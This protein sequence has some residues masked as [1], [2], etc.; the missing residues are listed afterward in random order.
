MSIQRIVSIIKNNLLVVVF[1]TAIILVIGATTVVLAGPTTLGDTFSDTLKIDSSDTVQIDT[2]TGEVTLAQCYQAT[3]SG[4][5]YTAST[6]VRDVSQTGD[7]TATVQ[8]DIY[9]DDNNCLFWTHNASPPDLTVCV[10]DNSSVYQ[11]LLW[12]K[13]DDSSGLKWADASHDDVAI[14]GYQ[15]AGSH[16]AGL[17]VG[18]NNQAPGGDNWLDRYYNSPSSPDDVFPAMDTCKD[19]GPRWRLPTILE[20]DGIRDMTVSSSPYTRLPD[21][22]SAYYWSSSE[23]SASEAWALDFGNGHVPDV[24]AKSDTRRVRCVR[25]Q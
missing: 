25:G 13:Q 2:S 16:V 1:S 7:A 19:K 11:N 18:D 10:A 9:C 3:D 24:N 15:I 14:T 17:D 12:A 21:V 22:A 20:L 8:K 5:S 6:T 4:W 23:T